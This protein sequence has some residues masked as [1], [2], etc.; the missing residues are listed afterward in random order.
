MV[1]FIVYKVKN[2]FLNQRLRL[3]EMNKSIISITLITTFGLTACQSTNNIT[4]NHYLYLQDQVI[5]NSKDF[6]EVF[7]KWIAAKQEKN[8]LGVYE[9]PS[10]AART[11]AINAVTNGFERYCDYIRG[12]LAIEK[13]SYGE[14]YVC[15]KEAQPYIA[16]SYKLYNNNQLSIYPSTPSTR[17]KQEESNTKR[18]L[19]SAKIEELKL[20]NGPSGTLVLDSGESIDFL[21]VGT[22]RN[23][24]LMHLGVKNGKQVG[25]YGY[26]YID[27]VA[28]IDFVNH[29]FTKKSGGTSKYDT[30][31]LTKSVDYH[32]M[33]VG[34]DGLAV[35]TV[36]PIN[37]QLLV[38]RYP[39]LIGVSTVTFKES[40]GK[41]GFMSSEYDITP[42]VNE[43]KTY[44]SAEALKIE[45]E[46]DWSRY[47]DFANLPP[48]TVQ[49]VVKLVNSIA[50]DGYGPYL[51]DNIEG[52]KYGP[53]V[54][55][56]SQIAMKERRY[57]EKG[58]KFTNETT[59]LASYILMS[60]MKLDVEGNSYGYVAK[61]ELQKQVLNH[62]SY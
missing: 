37:Q 29:T 28:S 21:R 55:A 31:G 42:Y 47:V 20:L 13:V 61:R 58:Y 5:S 10:L 30:F 40:D 16:V 41:G 7:D 35:V 8:T 60:W 25:D 34:I 19:E 32:A 27:D 11:D 9:F 33:G 6:D 38:R 45:T 56:M 57:L 53:Y 22:I 23:R 52:F 51:G 54:Y 3:E 15:S 62:F 2:T 17:L 44:F 43:L 18:E 14:K 46:R 4:E 48:K 39:N 1:K 12:S 26:T 36:D 24:E 49:R 59:P 50:D